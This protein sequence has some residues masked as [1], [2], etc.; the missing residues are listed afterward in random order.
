MNSSSQRSLSGL[1]NKFRSTLQNI[2][3]RYA[4]RQELLECERVGM[5]DAML[6]DLNMSRGELDPLVRNHPLSTRLFGAMATRLGVDPASD[7]PTTKRILQRTCAVCAHQTECQQWLDSGRSEGF[8][9][10][11]PNSDYWRDLK[12]RIQN[13]RPRP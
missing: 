4:L 11:C 12:A 8:E 13:A 5:L 7:G 6:A 9:A 3:A 1:V 2:G 10:F